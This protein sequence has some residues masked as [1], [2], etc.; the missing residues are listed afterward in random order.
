MNRLTQPALPP[1]G[2][3]SASTLVGRTVSTTASLSF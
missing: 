3:A 2:V 1:T